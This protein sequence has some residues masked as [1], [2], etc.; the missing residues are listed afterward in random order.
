[1]RII[2]ISAFYHDSAAALVEDGQILA[3]AQE[4]RF[5][6]RKH[7]PSFPSESLNWILDQHNL[8]I[9]DIDA[10]AYY[11]DPKIKLQRVLDSFATT[12]P[13]AFGQ[14]KKALASQQNKLAVRDFIAATTGFK[15][16]ILY[17]RHHLSHAASAFYPSPFK[18]AAF[19]TVDGVGEWDTTT[20]GVG[21]ESEISIHK[22]IEF[23]HSMGLL[24]SAFTYYAGFKINSGEYKLMGLA[25]YG[26][27]KYA[28]LILDNMLDVKPDGSF[29]LNLE[30]FGHLG[31]AGAITDAFASLFGQPRRDPETNLTQFHMDVAASIQSVL[32]H[33]L[34]R[35]CRFVAN[36]TGEANLCLAG[37]VALNCVANGK[38]IRE[39]MFNELWIQPASGDAGGAIGSALYHF[40]RRAGSRRPKPAM[41]PYLGPRFSGSEIEAYLRRRN[42]PYRKSGAL[43]RETAELLSGGAIIGWFQGPMEFG[44]RALGNRSILGDPRAKNMQ[45]EMNLRI[46]Y[47][48]SFRPFAPIILE[49]KVADW[50]EF[51]GKSPYML[52]VA[53]LKEEKRIA[54]TEQESQLFGIEKLNTIRSTV[55]AITHVDY[56]ARLQTVSSDLNPRLHRLLEEFDAL[57]GCPILVN[58]SFNVRGEPIVLSPD[59]AYTCFMRTG[60]THLILDEYIVTKDEQPVFEES[61]DWREQFELD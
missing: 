31:G 48:E 21:N 23:P 60:M 44:P 10:I 45:K 34:L 1:M 3:A 7:D 32:E 56:S 58:T 33:V 18:R 46:K 13:G 12:W 22:K 6:R 43:E 17:T 59:D 4:E 51:H 28:Q 47:R 9:D 55:P 19:L 52:I 42:I 41:N 5:S 2:G 38:I 26:E 16:E 27:P 53:P 11:E 36:E 25:P 8:D 20:F 54:L 14:F 49:D 61:K 29:R 50:F 15:G 24:Y 30:Y 57:T 39:G 37:G 40:H 35:I